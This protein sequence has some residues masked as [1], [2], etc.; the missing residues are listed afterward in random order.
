MVCVC[1][2]KSCT[3]RGQSVLFCHSLQYCFKTRFLTDPRTRLAASRSSN[4]PQPQGWN[5]VEQTARPGFSS[6]NWDLN[7][8]LH[9]FTASSLPHR[10]ISTAPAYCCFL[11]CCCFACFIFACLFACSCVFLF[12]DRIFLSK[13]VQASHNCSPNSLGPKMSLP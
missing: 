6:E 3:A 9:A 11:C 7:S 5:Y 2:C 13:E 1:M 4:L 12:F 10:A 8:S